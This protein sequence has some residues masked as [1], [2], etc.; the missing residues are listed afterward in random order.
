MECMINCEGTT[1][2]HFFDENHPVSIELDI[3]LGRAAKKYTS[4]KFLRIDGATTS[5]VC[6]KLMIL[7]FPTIMAIRNKVVLDLLSDYHGSFA[8][9]DMEKWILKS[10]PS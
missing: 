3:M 8:Q 9:R 5:F 4:C 2:V 10:L 1:M 6:K 7:S